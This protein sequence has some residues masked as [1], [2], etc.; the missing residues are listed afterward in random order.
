MCSQSKY[1]VLKCS[2]F[3]PA[4]DGNCGLY[5][6]NNAGNTTAALVPA[7]MRATIVQ[8]DAAYPGS[9]G[10]YASYSFPCRAVNS[11]VIVQ[12][13]ATVR[14]GVCAC[15]EG[16]TSYMSSCLTQTAS[17]CLSAKLFYAACRCYEVR[18]TT[19]TVLG[20]SSGVPYSLQD[21][22]GSVYNWNRNTSAPL[23][24][25]YGRQFPGNILNGSDVLFTQCWNASDQPAHQVTAIQTCTLHDPSKLA[26]GP[27]LSMRDALF[28]DG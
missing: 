3:G 9:C 8:S 23:V 16:T 27:A 18:C 12:D 5:D 13:V 24:D 14:H 2:P 22:G 26:S 21:L 10:R 4:D 25:D 15:L 6:G 1:S 28:L 19:G 17:L 7:G 11:Q 20:N